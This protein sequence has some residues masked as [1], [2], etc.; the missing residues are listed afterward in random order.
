MTNKKGWTKHLRR[1]NFVEI[2]WLQ[3]RA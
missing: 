3:A 1:H 2:P